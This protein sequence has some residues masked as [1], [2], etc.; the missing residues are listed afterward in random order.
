MDSSPPI[1][2]PQQYAT[3]Y[4]EL[5]AVDEAAF[6]AFLRA[7]VGTEPE[8]S[9][10]A[11]LEAGKAVPLSIDSRYLV[12]GVLSLI[13]IAHA[14]GVLLEEL[15]VAISQSPDLELDEQ[16]REI[17]L[18]RLTQLF[19]L[20]NLV[21]LSRALTLLNDFPFVYGSTRIVTDLRPICDV[22]TGTEIDAIGI[23]HHLTIDGFDT[24]EGKSRTVR[25]TLD[26]ED[27]LELVDALRRETRKH[28]ALR[29]IVRKS[30][31]PLV[32]LT[33]K[34]VDWPN[35]AALSGDPA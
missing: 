17:L 33:E 14:E 20:P 25:I 32:T 5:G 19:A 27:L 21:P 35:D 4:E 2:V 22:S 3:A 31:I 10:S 12:Y 23:V 18:G 6:D 30:E 28:A 1:R 11:A 34:N 13:S 29:R 16:A 15:P 9:L 26:D 8:V 7:L 24:Q